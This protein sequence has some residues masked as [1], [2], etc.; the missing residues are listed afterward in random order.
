MSEVVQHLKT[1]YWGPEYDTVPPRWW[2]NFL[3]ETLIQDIPEKMHEYAICKQSE[4]NKIKLTFHSQST[5]LL[6]ILR[7]T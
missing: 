6:F 1:W 4:S 5:L 3:S 2:A 7:W